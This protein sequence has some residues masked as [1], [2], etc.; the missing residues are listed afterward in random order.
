MYLSYIF[1]FLLGLLSV[2]KH[3]SYFIV[4]IFLRSSFQMMLFKK[5]FHFLHAWCFHHFNLLGKKG[6]YF[7]LLTLCE[8]FSTG[9][10][11]LRRSLVGGACICRSGGNLQ[12]YYMKDCHWRKLWQ[13]T[14]PSL[15]HSECL[16]HSGK[17]S[18]SPPSRLPCNTLMLSSRSETSIVRLAPCQHVTGF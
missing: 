9:G 2:A 11:L 10:G 18:D 17:P 13:Q 8:S 15:F 6:L 3:V 7:V 12:P 14:K 4:Y 5:C 16:G 1:P